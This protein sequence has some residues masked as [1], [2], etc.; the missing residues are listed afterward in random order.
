MVLHFLKK[1]SIVINKHECTCYRFHAEKAIEIIHRILPDD[2]LLLASSKRVKG[3]T[4]M[5]IKY[6]NTLYRCTESVLSYLETT[7]DTSIVCCV[8]PYLNFRL[9][10][11]THCTARDFL[12]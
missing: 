11:V 3:I 2:H 12:G 7:G 6:Y 10:L 4:F 5:C 1:L 8:H 9:K